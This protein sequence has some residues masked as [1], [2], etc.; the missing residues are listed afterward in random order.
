[1]LKNFQKI[2]KY[3]YI[4][5]PLLILASLFYFYITGKFEYFSIVTLVAGVAIGLLFFLRFYD[6]IVKK[7][8]ADN[9]LFKE[10]VDSQ[11]SFARRATQWEQDTVVG[12]RMAFDYYFGPKG[13]LK[14]A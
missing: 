6:D 5:A 14:K 7:K 10:I 9:P 3:L 1:M 2:E 12:R 13:T 4:V 8:S 11:I